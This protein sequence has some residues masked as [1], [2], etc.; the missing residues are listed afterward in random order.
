MS[1]FLTA[2]QLRGV[3]RWELPLL[4]VREDLPEEPPVPPPPP[5]PTAQQLEEIE[6]AAY[7]EGWAR[8]HADG[9]TQGYSDGAAVVRD[10]AGRLRGLVERMAR[11]LSELDAEVERMLVALALD[12]GRRLAQKALREDPTLV[13]GIIHDAIAAL[14][15]PNRNV[16]VH[17]HPED[18]TLLKE[19]L[20][21]P[22]E[23]SEWRLIADAELARGDCRIVTDSTQI[24]ARLDTREAGLAK[25]LLGDGA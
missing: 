25:A 24:D 9:Y 6:R 19:T 23:I 5:P 3:T 13:V 11:P 20:T 4:Q 17:V 15:G 1:S 21:L 16:R 2:D 14:N 10:Q 12:V 22:G 8:G 18:A 7:E